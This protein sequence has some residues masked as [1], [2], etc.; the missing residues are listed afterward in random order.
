MVAAFTLF[1]TGVTKVIGFADEG[2]AFIFGKAADAS[3]AW[4]FIFAVKV[5]PIII[6]FASLMAVLY[7]LGVMQRVVAVVAWVIRRALGVSGTEALSS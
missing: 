4:G 5:L 7:H 3:G 1:A 2:T 6:F